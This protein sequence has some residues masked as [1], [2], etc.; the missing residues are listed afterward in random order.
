MINSTEKLGY[1]YNELKE[2]EVHSS[3]KPISLPDDTIFEMMSFLETKDLCKSRLIS[4]NW[5]QLAMMHDNSDEWKS[6]FFKKFSHLNLERPLHSWRQDFIEMRRSIANNLEK[7][8]TLN[9]IERF[10]PED[11]SQVVYTE[12][13]SDEG[14]EIPLENDMFRNRLC[15]VLRRNAG[16]FCGFQL[17]GLATAI[18]INGLSLFLMGLTCKGAEEGFGTCL[19]SRISNP[20]AISLIVGPHVFAQALIVFF[21]VSYIFR[22]HLDRP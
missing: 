14:T 6:L 5:N 7:L 13:D 15:R 12:N 21:M 18:T 1:Q 17:M 16:V 4:K 11:G 19:S 2:I 22:R 10:L 8:Q 20:S 3:H 9:S